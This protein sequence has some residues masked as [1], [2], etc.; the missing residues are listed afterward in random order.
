MSIPTTRLGR[1][2][3]EVLQTRARDRDAVIAHMTTA[4]GLGR[5]LENVPPR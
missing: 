1:T 2:G 4:E 3:L 5:L